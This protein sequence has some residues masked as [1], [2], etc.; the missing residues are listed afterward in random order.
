[1][2]QPTKPPLRGYVGAFN[3]PKRCKSVGLVQFCSV[4]IKEGRAQFGS[5]L[6]PLLQS[7][8]LQTGCKYR[9]TCSEHGQTWCGSAATCCCS[10]RQHPFKL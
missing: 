9:K 10:A 4:Y 1:V 6:L 8:R 5:V 7:M 3:Q 2:K